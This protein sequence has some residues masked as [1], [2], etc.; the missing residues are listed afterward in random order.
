MLNIYGLVFWL[1]IDESNLVAYFLKNSHHSHLFNK[2]AKVQKFLLY[3]TLKK[4]I[5]PHAY[6]NRWHGPR[7]RRHGL[8]NPFSSLTF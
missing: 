6:S 7:T 5:I 4:R 1:I 8:S 3:I 2:R